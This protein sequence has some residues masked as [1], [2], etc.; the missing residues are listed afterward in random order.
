MPSAIVPRSACLSIKQAES[1][2]TTCTLQVTIVLIP[3]EDKQSL[4]QAFACFSAALHADPMHLDT[5]LA[6]GNL[7]RSCLLLPEATEMFRRAYEVQP[8]RTTTQQ[9]LAAALTD[10]GAATHC[11][12]CCCDA[13][14]ASSLFHCPYSC[15]VCKHHLESFSSLLKG[16]LRVQAP[17]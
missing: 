9:T 12:H 16:L 5:L 3:K 6:C 10:L 13:S 17:N 14:L 8:R 15:Y 11:W 2:G 7:H 4:L 1:V